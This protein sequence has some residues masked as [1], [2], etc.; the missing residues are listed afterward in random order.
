MREGLS[1]IGIR[2]ETV[3][4]VI[5]SHMHYDHAG[6]TN[7]FP[8]ARFH[9]QEAEMAYCTGRC[10]GHAVMRAPF[11]ASD[12]SAM[13]GRVFAG[14]VCFHDGDGELAPGIT[15]HKI[16]GH[17]KGLQ[18]VRV[19]TARGPV[20]LASDATHLYANLERNHPFP[21]LVDMDD[22]LKGFETLRRLAPSPAHIIPGH[23][24]LVLD[25]YPL[26]KPG[27]EGIVRLDA[28]PRRG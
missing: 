28:E 10:M 8:E 2:A 19:V 9:I 20:V 27:L 11:E 7:L 13:V 3:T 12:V 22:Y 6:N 16:G 23:D 4:D 21:I 24:P 5:V 15:I 18:V 17:T 1:A 14:R 25:L 26:A